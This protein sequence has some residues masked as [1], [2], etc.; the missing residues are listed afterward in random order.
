MSFILWVDSDS[1]PLRHRE[2]ILRRA[3]KNNIKTIFVADRILKDVNN[4]ISEHS[5]LLRDPLRDKLEKEELR[6]IKSTI[7]MITVATGSNSADDYIVE[8]A[9]SGQL[10]IT[11]DIPLAARLVEKG[12]LVI[13]DRGNTFDSNNIKERLSIRNSMYII[14]EMGS[15]AEKQKRF[16]LKLL[17]EFSNS[18]DCAL[19]LFGF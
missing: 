10:C 3:I 19:H 11:H 12:V 9:E 16:D 14:R 5:K 17:E 15:N 7:K 4:A 18:F 8:N 13:D 1:V 2:I 6:K